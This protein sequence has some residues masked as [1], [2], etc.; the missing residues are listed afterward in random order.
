MFAFKGE[1]EYRGLLLAEF[2]RMTSHCSIGNPL[3]CVAFASQ[4]CRQCKTVN[5]LNTSFDQCRL[6]LSSKGEVESAAEVVG[7]GL[8]ICLLYTSDAADE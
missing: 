7:G 2:Q 1:D 6:W 4:P 5:L 3:V 8:S